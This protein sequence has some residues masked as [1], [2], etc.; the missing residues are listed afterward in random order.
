[1]T[2]LSKPP[3]RVRLIA[4]GLLFACCVGADLFALRAFWTRRTITPGQFRRGYFERFGQEVGLA[5]ADATRTNTIPTFVLTDDGE[6]AIPPGMT[7]IGQ[8]ESDVS[9]VVG[10]SLAAPY[11][12]IGQEA[13]LP[14]AHQPLDDGVRLVDG[15]TLSF[16]SG[17]LI[18]APWDATRP[19]R[20]DKAR[21]VALR[22]GCGEDG[23]A[24]A[25]VRMV[26]NRLE[27]R[28]GRCS[29]SEVLA[30]A[31]NRAPLLAAI[32]GPEWMTETR[33][34]SWVG[35]H[36]FVG[37]IVAAVVVKSAA[38]W[39][40]LGAIAAAA[41]AAVMG[42][43][44]VWMAAAAVL[45]WPLMLIV[46]LIASVLRLVV[47]GLRRVPRRMRPVAVAAVV[48]AVAAMVAL[49]WP[50]ETISAP[51]SFA[52]THR[53]GEACAVVG[54]STVKGE[55]LRGE[56]GG[57]RQ[58]LDVNCPPCR[59]DTAGMYAGGETVTWAREAY[60]SSRMSFG[61]DGALIF[62]G[63][64]NDD[65]FNAGTLSVPR[66]V[67]AA[68]QGSEAWHHNVQA[69]ASGS[70]GHIEAQRAA[71]VELMHCAHARGARFLF[72]HDFLVSDLNSGRGPERSEMLRRRREVVVDGSGTFV[73]MLQTFA[74]E[75][76]VSWFNDYVHLSVPAHERVASFACD[77]LRSQRG[78][79]DKPGAGVK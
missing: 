75:A 26:G 45:T 5:V 3:R 21:L 64:V 52:P 49:S 33:R 68:Q 39:W 48:A 62:L 20:E 12:V 34:P 66:L 15:R 55:G 35:T 63:G 1:M 32:A 36:G 57:L 65:F 71:L 7:A 53:G 79:P 14:P 70:L 58:V 6:L 11:I 69:A 9:F 38:M 61:A 78:L 41:T 54:Y 24:T 51:I 77:W 44:S 56:L 67:V 31:D 17:R 4:A 74:A 13:P 22:D 16:E 19:W 25:T 76:G 50:H 47:A 18:L 42:L 60:C 40:S 43:G 8:L 30:P 59:D 27:A 72:L 29:V 2:I 46:A 10:S 73:D 28:L 23:R 37:P